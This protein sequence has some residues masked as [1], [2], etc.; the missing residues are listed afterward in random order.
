MR[1]TSIKQK[2]K[3]F[4]LLE[5]FVV[6]ATLA[7]L[8]ALVLPRLAG[9]TKSPVIMCINN[10]RQVGLGFIV[11][12]TDHTNQLPMQ[13]SVTN[14]GSM[15]Y[16]GSGTPATYFQTVS[17]YLGGY[18][19]V[20]LCPSDKTK[21]QATKGAA[22][23]D[24]NISYFISVDATPVLTNAILAGDRN[25]EVAGQPVAPGLFI[26]TTNAAVGWTREMH[27]I[28]RNGVWVGCGN[29]LFVD[30]HV[31]RFQADLPTAIQRQGLATNRLAVP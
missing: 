23:S 5:L 15:E 18:W 2:T 10:L 13:T 20:L 25:L 17:N 3:A 22:P 8:V 27:K 7:V 30:G 26:L 29:L 12:A 24:R 31:Q 28:Q 9:S 11:F 6:L 1:A 14:G 16:V 4:S 19:G 21:Q